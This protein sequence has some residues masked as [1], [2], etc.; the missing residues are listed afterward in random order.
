MNFAILH[1]SVIPD[2]ARIVVEDGALR[3]QNIPDPSL[4]DFHE[5]DTG[6]SA[7]IIVDTHGDTYD[8]TT[9][10]T[11]TEGVAF[12]SIRCM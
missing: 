8:I 9:L 1:S 7:V 10:D 5:D 12:F 2:H 4:Q 11:H 3:I 6:D